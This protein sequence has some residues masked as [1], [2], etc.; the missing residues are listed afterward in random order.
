MPTGVY[1]RT[2]PPW[3]KGMKVDRTKYPN[4]GHF[5]K[6]SEKAKEKMRNSHL[7]K[8]PWNIG[9][10][11]ETDSRVRKYSTNNPSHIKKGNIPWIKG[12]HLSKKTKGKISLANRGKI[13]WN[14]GKSHPIA[15]LNP[16]I[17]KK[18]HI[19][20]NKGK[21]LSEKTIRKIREARLKQIMPSRDTLIEIKLQKRL[22]QMGISF[23]THKPILNIT[24]CDIFIEPN[25]CIFAD[26]CFFHGC[27][28]CYDKNF[29]N[30]GGELYSKV[31]ARKFLDIL[32]TQKLINEGYTVLR[33]WE[34]DINEDF[35]DKV[36]DKIIFT[37]NERIKLMVK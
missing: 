10:T 4:M 15:S 26:G 11:K 31:R 22:K 14:K 19:P 29:F 9:L 1:A 32:T 12:K 21:H 25:V 37:M 17:F 5:K 24:Q 30:K 35:E 7:N 16:Q 28:K 34:H 33:F 20:F 6:H 2:K 13:P 18:G 36:L 8:I 27:E 3:N 23:E